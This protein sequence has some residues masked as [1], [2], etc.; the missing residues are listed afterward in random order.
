MPFAAGFAGYLQLTNIR[1]QSCISEISIALLVLPFG[2]NIDCI[3][4]LQEWK[5][6]PGK[7]NVFLFWTV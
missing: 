7:Q 5:A 2:K 3:M 4:D 6:N 1:E